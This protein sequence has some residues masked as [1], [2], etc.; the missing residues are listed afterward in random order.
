MGLGGQA[1]WCRHKTAAWTP[2]ITINNKAENLRSR[3]KIGS[4]A[5]SAGTTQQ[6]RAQAGTD[7]S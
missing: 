4:L 6:H 7:L 3:L 2:E 1:A 5:R